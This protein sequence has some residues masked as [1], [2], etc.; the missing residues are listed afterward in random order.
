V[1][2][3]WLRKILSYSSIS[4]HPSPIYQTY[5][6][7]PNLLVL[8]IFSDATRMSHVMQLAKKYAVYPRQFLFKTIPPVDP[9][10]N[11]AAIPQLFADPWHRIGG[12]FHIA[13]MQEGGDA[14]DSRR[15]DR[16]RQGTHQQTRGH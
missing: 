3:S 13:T 12:T 8:C 1:R 7:V 5:L 16:P 14:H 6:K 2:A 15:Q 4:A 11:A 10:L 9:L